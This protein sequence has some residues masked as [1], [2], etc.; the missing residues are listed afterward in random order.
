MSSRLKRVTATGLAVA[1]PLYL[2]GVIVESATGADS[3]VLIQDTAAG[4][5]TN[6][7]GID[8]KAGESGVWVTAD[9]D[10]VFFDNGVYVT[11]VGAGASVTLEYEPAG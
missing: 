3:D 7:F 9:R 10:G 11:L 1:G 5:G 6:I 4:G 8:A 2:R